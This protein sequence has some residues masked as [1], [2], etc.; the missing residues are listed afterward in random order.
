[1]ERINF[2]DEHKPIHPQRYL[3][4]FP[5]CTRRWN[6]MTGRRDSVSVIEKEHYKALAK[7]AAALKE[8]DG[9]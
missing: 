9:E 8:F 1:M 3:L 7:L 2:G 4:D 6:R 5:E